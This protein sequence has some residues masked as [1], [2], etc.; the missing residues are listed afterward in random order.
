L[1]YGQCVESNNEDDK[2]TRDFLILSLL[3]VTRRVSIT[4]MLRL[5][6]Y[7]RDDGYQN[8]FEVKIEEE[9]SV[10]TLKKFIKK[11][12]AQ[13]F[14]DMDAKSLVLWNKPVP[15]HRNLKENVD[16][17]SLGDDELL[18]PLDILSDVLPS[19]LEKQT[20]HIIVDRPPSSEL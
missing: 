9:E 14:R 3:T 11:E 5:F 17:L 12:A 18:Q 13:T 4:T 19:V 10:A 20:V 15:F 8:A 6:C 16:A 7:V 1:W 2:W